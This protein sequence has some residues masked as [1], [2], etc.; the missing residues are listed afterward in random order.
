[1][2]KATIKAFLEAFAVGDA[3]GKATEQCTR[4][5]IEARYDRVDTLLT[6]EESLTHEDLFHGQVTDDTEQVVYLIR[7]YAEKGCIT[8]YDT[9]MAL[10]RWVNETDAANKYIGANSLRALRSIADGADVTT[11]GLNGITC[12]GMMR[13]PAAFFMSREEELVQSVVNCLMP[14]H[15]T[16]VAIESAVCY[17]YAMKAALKGC[18]L[19][20]ILA[21]ACIGAEVG[22]PYGSQLRVAAAAPSCAARIRFLSK[23][24]PTLENEQ[25]LKAFLYDILGTTQESCDCC[26]AAFALLIWAKEDVHLAIRL[27]TEMG[28]DTDTI[29]CLAAGLCT[30]YAG[31][32]NLPADMVQLVSEANKLD[33]DELAEMVLR[34]R[35]AWEGEEA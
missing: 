1:M 5:E 32:H 24:L 14:T 30:L 28:G 22:K 21:E 19:Q 29:A 7:E 23:F 11:T 18:D 17:A 13:T 20:T 10:L 6:P 4:Q 25:E 35:A 34:H 15:Y 31:G 2:N 33:F 16:G 12:G 9:A 8:P 26:A 27:A 3:Y